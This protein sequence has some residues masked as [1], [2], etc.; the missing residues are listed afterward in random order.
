METILRSTAVSMICM[1][2]ALGSASAGNADAMKAYSGLLKTLA[3]TD[4]VR[5]DL[6]GPAQK[7]ELKTFLDYAAEPQAAD[8]PTR[9][10]QLAFWINAHNAC[11]M[12][13]ILDHMPIQDVMKITGFRDR[14][15]CRVAGQERTLVNIESDVIRP[16]FAEPRVHFALWW[17]VKGG[18]RLAAA[19]YEEKTLGQMLESRTDLFVSDEKNVAFAGKPA[20][21]TLSPVFDWYKSDF[22]KANDDVLEFIRKRVPKDKSALVPKKLSKV[23]FAA[24][25]WTLDQ[26]TQKN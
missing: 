10:A 11:V 9:E 13:H 24:L 25:D 20:E 18:P 6:L 16:L 5:W 26:T 17:G 4:G 23:K 8:Q 19:P 22:G 15:K 3:Q 2:F 14:L 21:L 12:K 7:G 1:F